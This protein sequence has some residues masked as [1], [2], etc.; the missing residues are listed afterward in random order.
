MTL[1]LCIA[2]CGGYARSVLNAVSD[3]TDEFKFYFASR[4]ESKARAYCDTYDGAGYFGGYEEAAADPRVEAMY[5][6]TPHDMHLGNARMAAGHGKHVLM[7]KPIARTLEEAG[8]MIETVEA[9]G[10][11]LMVAENYR[12]LPAVARTRE[13]M[14]EGELGELRLIQI[15]N[16][17]FQTTSGWRTSLDSVGGG[18]FIDGGIHGIDILVNIGGLPDSVFALQPPK[19]NIQSEG[20]DGMVMV[21]KLPE[22]GVGLINYSAATASNESRQEVAVTFSKGV[23][24]FDPFGVD[25]TVNTRDGKRTEA[26]EDGR[27]AALRAMLREFRDC[28]VENREPAMSARDGLRDLAVVL[29]AYRSVAT[30]EEVGV[31]R[32]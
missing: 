8:R 27:T 4:D 12:F 11:K 29:A 18:V 30:S 20:E 13:L 1:S 7:E 19:V 21:A 17:G 6:F 26:L 16:E 9:A 10:V 5:F 14:D 22:G 2:G 32:P 15:Y 28:I 25:L 31:D 3:M 23:V 24:R